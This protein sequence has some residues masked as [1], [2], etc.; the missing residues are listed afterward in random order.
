MP[1]SKEN[2][3][4]EAPVQTNLVSTLAT[5]LPTKKKTRQLAQLTAVNTAVS[6]KQNI[7][8][9]IMWAPSF[10]DVSLS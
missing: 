9:V 5:E 3:Y 2:T 4:S 10:T 7:I 6:S 8:G 1:K